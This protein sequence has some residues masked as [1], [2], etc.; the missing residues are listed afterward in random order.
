LVGFGLQ[1]FTCVVLENGTG[2]DDA[3]ES[4]YSIARVTHIDPCS[5]KSNRHFPVMKNAKRDREIWSVI[6]TAQM[7]LFDLFRRSANSAIAD[8]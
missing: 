1:L 8:P 5:L 4:L 7:V 3:P 2:H 6:A